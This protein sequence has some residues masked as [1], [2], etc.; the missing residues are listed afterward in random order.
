MENS[1]I[2]ILWMGEATYL[3]TGYSVYGK[4][5]LTYLHNTGKYEIAELASYGGVKDSR[6]FEIPWRYYGNLP[7]NQTE[8]EE[9][10][11]I[12]SNQWGLWRSDEVILDFKP[13]VIIDIRDW[14]ASEFVGHSP[15]RGLFK[16]ILMPTVDSA[17][18]KEQWLS[19]FI[20]AD[21][22]FTYSEFGRDTLLKETNN[23]INFIDIA[24]PAANYKYYNPVLDKRKHKEDFGIS[25]DSKIIGTVMRN[26]KRK[27]FP[28]LIKMFKLLLEKSNDSKNLYM[29]WHTAYPDLGW[30]I[31]KLIR[32]SGIGHK[33]LFTYTCS[34]CGHIFPSF[35]NDSFQ[36]CPKCKK[37]SARLPSADKG[38]D[39][40]DLARI[41]NCFDVYVQYSVAEGF[42]LPL[43]EAA[44]CGVPVY[45]VNYSAMESIL[46]N[47]KGIPINP[48]HMFLESE[49]G[50]ER[51][52]P[53]NQD[54]ANKLD[55]FFRKSDVEQIDIGKR[56]YLECRK[57]YDYEVTAKKWEKAIDNLNINLDIWENTPPNI[58][59]IN[60]NIPNGLS[61][62]QFV[63]WCILNLW[64]EPSQLDSFIELR[65]IRDLNYGVA[66][67][68]T[69]DM[70]YA[71]DSIVNER[72][73]H[74]FTRENVIDEMIRLA[75][76]RNY[77]EA[78]RIGRIVEEIPQFIS[79]A[80]N[81]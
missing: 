7:T 56:T 26:Q 1:K 43:V 58:K 6:R 75:E 45:A 42:G 41:M 17:P 81:R 14:W 46:K 2:R 50:A 74:K 35:F 13:H 32:E 47:I 77:W 40:V 31:P 38:V 10:N 37:A 52:W 16:W 54:C 79:E 33:I 29:Y 22:I 36:V 48:L 39:T 78:R 3:S 59:N 72:H 49:L 30:D 71:D 4:E 64:G 23:K 60:K 5:I 55:K 11:K 62:E 12:S 27:L 8:K 57:H 61:N 73:F 21:A 69:M 76:H 9:Y 19:T 51:A 63:R 15:Y 67:M 24:S 80:H 25:G 18:Q 44:A 70:F 66:H 53:D 68:G 20:N 28:E 65:M 34:G